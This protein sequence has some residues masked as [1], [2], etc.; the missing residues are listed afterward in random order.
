MSFSWNKLWDSVKEGAKTVASEIG[1]AT[2]YVGEKIQKAGEWIDRTINDLGK[3]QSGPKIDTG[4]SNGGSSSSSGSGS[5]TSSIN[6]EIKKK[7]TQEENEAIERYQE[8]VKERAENRENS[9]RNAY[10]K[11]YKEYISDFEEVFDAELMDEIR[12]F[13]N[14]KS[15]TFRNTLRD[16]V[17]TKVNSSY[18]PWKQLISNHPTSKE[19]QSFCDK[20]YTDADNNLLDLLQSSIEDTNKFISKCIIKFNDDKAKALTEMKE[21]LIKLTADEETKAQELKKIAEELIVAQFIA[22]ET[23]DEN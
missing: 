13:V 6:E 5:N 9:V 14:N 19:L 7:K 4:F 8:E 12:T 23:V 3:K 17:N 2:K 10:K 15:N 21:S 1:K 20:V 11:I 18:R 22:N 16:E